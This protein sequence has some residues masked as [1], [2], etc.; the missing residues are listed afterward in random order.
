M[1]REGGNQNYANH[2]HISTATGSALA[3]SNGWVKNNKGSW[4]LSTNGKAIKI[5]EAFYVDTKFTKIAANQGISF[6]TI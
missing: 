4:V 3:G 2:F 5:N 6:K 1:F